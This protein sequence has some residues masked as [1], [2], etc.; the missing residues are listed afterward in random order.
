MPRDGRR[1]NSE[2]RHKVESL[3][4]KY[5]LASVLCTAR[6]NGH[7]PSRRKVPTSFDLLTRTRRIDKLASGGL[8]TIISAIRYL[9]SESVVHFEIFNHIVDLLFWILVVCLVA[10]P[11][12][13]LSIFTSSPPP[14][15][16]LPSRHFCN[17]SRLPST[18]G[19]RWP[20]ADMVPQG[21]SSPRQSV[22][23]PSRPPPPQVSPDC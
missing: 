12:M 4:P 21:T 23:S 17:L 2:T 5:I 16:S 15:A 7:L 1:R 13:P 11:S 20:S 8:E 19:R 14:W 6:N 18:N 10:A 22:S 9:T 3:R